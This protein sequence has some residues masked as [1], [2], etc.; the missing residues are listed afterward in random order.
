MLHYLLIAA[1]GALGASARFA[2]SGAVQ[3]AAGAEF[4]L[5]TL[6]VNVLGCAGIGLLGGLASGS[7][8]LREELRLF[9]AI[10]FLGGFTTFS[11]F[12]YETFLLLGARSVGPALANLALGNALCL[13]AVWAGFR[14]GARSAGG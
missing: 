1:G 2:L 10:G 6:A 12:G 3:R 9:A 8:G 7:E 4:P 5:G 11:T 13:A 14:V